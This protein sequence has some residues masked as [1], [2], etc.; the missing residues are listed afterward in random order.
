M[1]K[2][3]RKHERYHTLTSA[4]V[5]SDDHLDS[6]FSAEILNISRSGLMFKTMSFYESGKKLFFSLQPLPYDI[7]GTVKRVNHASDSYFHSVEFD[8]SIKLATN[9][10]F[11]IISRKLF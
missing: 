4:Q 2:E 10:I 5:K 11:K 3:R 6:L 7:E 9:D 1:F 8:G